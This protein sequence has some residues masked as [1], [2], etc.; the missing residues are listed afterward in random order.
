LYRAGGSHRLDTRPHVALGRKQRFRTRS[1]SMA[2]VRRLE[3]RR[4][5]GSGPEVKAC[6]SLAPESEC[7]SESIGSAGTRREVR[8]ES[9]DDADGDL[10]II[11]SEE[12]DNARDGKPGLGVVWYENPT[13]QATRR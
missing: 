5:P 2:T 13:R 3:S 9:S 6:Q 12:N 8:P 7:L 11:N 1:M 4:T 10:D